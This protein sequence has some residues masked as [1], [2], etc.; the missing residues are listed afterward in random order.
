MLNLTTI[1][2]SLSPKEDIVKDF[3]NDLARKIEKLPPNASEADLRERF[4]EALMNVL[5]RRGTDKYVIPQFEAPVS[6]RIGVEVIQY[7]YKGR[8]DALY[9]SA[10]IEFKRL[11]RILEDESV[12][13]EAIA[14]LIDYLV[15]MVEYKDRI[16][17]KHLEK[18]TGFAT[19]G[20]VLIRVVYRR[21][22]G[23][24]IEPLENIIA[25]LRK[26]RRKHKV[27]ELRKLILEKVPWYFDIYTT[28]LFE[29]RDGR[30]K[31]TL[32]GL[33]VAKL[34]ILAI[35]SVA[36]LKLSPENF[37]TQFG[38]EGIARSIVP[39]LISKLEKALIERNQ[40]VE[41]LYLFWKNVY[42]GLSGY[43]IDQVVRKQDY[44]ELFDKWGISININEIYKNINNVQERL[45]QLD[46][47]RSSKEVNELIRSLG[48]ILDELKR[49][50]SSSLVN[51]LRDI[52]LKLEKMNIPELRSIVNTCM[53][54]VIML[55]K[56]CL[57]LY[58]VHTYYSILLKL[59][60]YELA[61]LHQDAKIEP[62]SPIQ[63][64]SFLSGDRLREALENIEEGRLLRLYG[65]NNLVEKDIYSWYLYVWDKEI[66][67]K[68]IRPLIGK[69]LLFNLATPV[70]EPKYVKDLLKKLYQHLLPRGIRHDLGEYYTPDWLADFVIN[71]VNRLAKEKGLRPIG[72]PSVRVIDPACGSGT[73]LVATIH[74]VLDYFNNRASKVIES[75]SAPGYSKELV[76]GKVAKLG[77]ETLRMVLNN[78]V[79]LDINPL[80]VLTARINYLLAIAPLLQYRTIAGLYE[81]TIP[82]YMTDSILSPAMEELVSGIKPTRGERQRSLL[83]YISVRRR[84][85]ALIFELHS[86]SGEEEVS[87][88][89][90]ISLFKRVHNLELRKKIAEEIFNIMEK[91][92]SLE[93]SPPVEKYIDKIKKI[94]VSLENKY[95]T[96]ITVL[97]EEIEALKHTYNLIVELKERNR[98]HIWCSMLKQWISPLWLGEFDY[99]IG[100]PP[101]VQWESLP[102]TYRK[103]TQ[104]LWEIYG[105]FTLSGMDTILGGGKKDL[106]ALMTY[107]AI[108]KF[109]KTNGVIGFL[110]TQAV[111]KTV[112]AGE[113]FRRFKVKDIPIGLKVIHDLVEI[114]PFEKAQNRTTLFIAVKGEKTKYPIP[115][116]KWIPKSS[117]TIGPD[118]KLDEVLSC[119]IF[120][121]KNAI[122]LGL[123]DGAPLIDLAKV[124]IGKLD[125]LERET[126]YVA[127]AGVSS[128]GINS[129]YFLNIVMDKGNTVFVKNVV[130]GMH[131]SRLPQDVVNL[132]VNGKWELEKDLLYP[133]IRYSNVWRWYLYLESPKERTYFLMVQDPIK[134]KG[135]S[136]SK[137]SSKYPLTYN[138]LCS[139]KEV[140]KK[141]SAYKRYYNEQ[142]PFYSI[143]DVGTYTFS[144]YKVVMNRMGD[145]LRCA[146]VQAI[147][148]PYLGKRPI[149]PENVLTFI[150]VSSGDEAYYLAAIINSTIFRAFV[151]NITR[152]TKS[153]AS[154]D[155][156]N[157][158]LRILNVPKYDWDNNDHCRL[159]ILSKEAHNIAKEIVDLVGTP[160]ILSELTREI[161]M[162]VEK[163]DSVSSIA[164]KLGY[165]GYAT[166]V[167][168]ISRS[169]RILQKHQCI[170]L[171]K[172]G[173]EVYVLGITNKGIKA[174]ELIHKLVMVEDKID[175][176]VATI[177]GFDKD[178]LNDLKNEIKE[179]MIERISSE[180]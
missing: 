76:I 30:L 124:E 20:Y 134:R 101:W 153:F 98:D 83:D 87:L 8:I 120:K 35:E 161:M 106:S 90:P 111:F 93:R 38:P 4:H 48:N 127:K 139:F 82:V 34:L 97:E 100:N 28:R 75:L 32:E 176:I 52:V 126:S 49:G 145:E 152:G 178:L 17:V 68:V 91:Y 89:I 86:P 55:D 158:V 46:H 70:L 74:R 114:K 164:D 141:R 63:K 122:P 7:G 150:P 148:D 53:N 60:A 155:L 85:D 108:D 61:S 160:E 140:L 14:Q 180:K 133:L 84:S 15:S 1:I 112:K 10:I 44:K 103:I 175:E 102:E 2:E 50:Y 43:S 167:R 144:D 24:K 117:I 143:F 142:A 42:L 39:V 71:E 73:F 29:I 172:I 9:N 136:E 170:R 22:L 138:Y 59:L 26:L 174:K 162:I 171:G 19:D 146:V 45:K 179:L 69:L 72:D 25:E 27:G 129:I 62:T 6:A 149:L 66:E 94:I 110:I 135:I 12:R 128:G 123:R 13:I 95:N 169:L 113:G 96:S 131:L 109:L 157:E 151:L 77:A 21:K 47:L 80:A 165:T 125:L 16:D 78:I 130:K 54:L 31:P 40:M 37:R 11:R 64:L 121:R 166:I 58:A 65:F 159:A 33:I 67:G 116:I 168:R 3:L 81:I 104:K 115:Y 88:K 177:L 57:V 99:V 5:K 79:G 107:I 118:S 41:Y 36:K 51:S 154:P 92:V 147:N 56:V 18:Y 163:G 23:E 173:N 105:L 132:L 137:L 156:V 119:I